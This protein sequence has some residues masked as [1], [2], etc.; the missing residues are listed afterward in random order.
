M[1]QRKILGFT[2]IELLVTVSIIAIL[3]AVGLANYS[4]FTKKARDSRR[5]ADLEA[6]RGALELY[7]AD[8]GR[9]P[10]NNALQSCGDS[11]SLTYTTG[12]VT[13][14]Y[15]Q[16]IPCDPETNTRYIYTVGSSP[17]LTYTLTACVEVD[18][19]SGTG[20]A[21]CTPPKRQYC[22]KQP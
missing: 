12:G 10:D 20:C 5:K 21:S 22:V 4:S 11:S 2:L 17:Y 13:N 1:K 7:R 8:R 6:I 14:T 15:M 18:Q 9:Y 16:K 3:S 19:A